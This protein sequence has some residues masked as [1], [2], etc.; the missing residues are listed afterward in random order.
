MA[1]YRAS[2]QREIAAVAGGAIDGRAVQ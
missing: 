2:W 1:S